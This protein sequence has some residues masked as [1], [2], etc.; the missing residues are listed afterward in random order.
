MSRESRY[1]T[2]GG[3]R[4]AAAG[5]G[6]GL[7]RLLR[8][9][10]FFWK[11]GGIFAL[12]FVGAATGIA[13][14]ANRAYFATSS[15][16]RMASLEM[17]GVA[18][19]LN[20]DRDAYQAAL[21][22]HEAAFAQDQ[23]TR[24]KWLA[25]YAENAGQMRD[26]LAIY[27]GLPGL[28]QAGRDRAAAATAAR[29]ALVQ[30]GDSVATRLRAGATL[31]ALTPLL[32]EFQRRL[33]A[34]HDALGAAEEAHTKQSAALAAQV[35][36]AGRQYMWLMG[37]GLVIFAIVGVLVSGLLSRELAVPIAR[38]A[39]VSERIAQGD[40]AVGAMS[41]NRSDEIGRLAASFDRM[42][43]FIRDML[44]R[45]QALTSDLAASSGS[46]SA[47]ATETSDSLSQLNTALEQI[48]QGAQEQAH[49]AQQSAE[50]VLEMSASIQNVAGGA[51]DI[52]GG[53]SRAVEV[54]RRGGEIVQGAISGM[55]GVRAS[56]VDAAAL[57]RAMG[58]RT[59]RIGKIVELISQIA[60]RTNL[61]ALNAAIEA[62]RAGEH[63]RGFAVVADE[64]RK[65]ADGSRKSAAEIADLVQ[66]IEAGTRRAVE[67]M[68]S[69]VGQV[70]REAI[71]AR[72]AMTALSEILAAVEGTGE[73]VG[74][75]SADAAVLADRA[76]RVT[77]LVQDVA[78]VAQESA[79]SAEEMS[80]QSMEV[81]AAMDTIAA[82]SGSQGRDNSETAALRRIA[83]QLQE[84]TGA[85]RL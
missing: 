68:E 7:L 39:Q 27:A 46:I 67:A 3:L 83:E 31:A 75:I 43:P 15:A 44:A 85:F 54:A 34:T 24:T 77:A 48:T 73:R 17:A 26:R 40:L 84:A 53:A 13:L 22:L 80:A 78:S 10:P 36:L 64:V 29:D 65:L 63:G 66:G 49:S 18:L 52:A 30:A 82:A 23:A 28:D 16:H 62:A 2:E 69:G 9:L 12:V 11:L 21:G 50:V 72:E 42:V 8:D 56:V 61:L 20:I 74:S 58:E 4:Q 1:G 76:G 41:L 25:F 6:G 47:A 37:I 57:V 81:A 35:Q 55:E 45:I 38:L 79:A 51:A 19:V 32:A 60:G 33:D 71:V 70:E 14:L 5:S 59:E